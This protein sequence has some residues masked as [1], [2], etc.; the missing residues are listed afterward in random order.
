MSLITLTVTDL[1]TRFVKIG[2]LFITMILI[3]LH[4][5]ESTLYVINNSSI[6][7]WLLSLA[8]TGLRKLMEFSWAAVGLTMLG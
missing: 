7:V 5:C 3:E 2:Y 6:M 1:W 4:I 8:F